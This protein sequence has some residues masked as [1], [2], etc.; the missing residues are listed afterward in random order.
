MNHVIIAPHP[1]DELIGCYQLLA[2]GVI[3]HIYFGP[4][5]LS[6]RRAEEA[7]SC[8]SYFKVDGIM[9]PCDLEAN[10]DLAK[11]LRGA[12][13]YLPAITDMH[14]EHRRLNSFFR[15][16]GVARRF[17]SVD[18]DSVPDKVY[19]G[20]IDSKRKLKALNLLYPS[21]ASLWENNASYYLFESI[22]DLDYSVLRKST[23]WFRQGYPHEPLSG[24]V[25]LAEDDKD[26]LDSYEGASHFAS[27]EQLAVILL[28]M[29]IT[30]FKIHS[31]MGIIE[32]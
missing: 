9:G 14:H 19:L 5:E 27:P 24:E 7:L 15:T 6:I 20:D 17:Y 13:V 1:D 31:P 18:L 25:W 3:T 12:T 16:Q 30:K 29:G 2:S 11:A 32:L 22:K 23:V 4:S 26:L 10:Q 28:S 21:Q 8:C